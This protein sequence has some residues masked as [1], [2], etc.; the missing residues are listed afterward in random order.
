[1]TG[2]LIVSVS[3][4]RDRSTEDIAEFSSLL[5]KR[6][7]PV[8]YLVAPRLAGGYRLLA[9]TSTV[10]WLRGRRQHGDAIVLHGFD[11]PASKKHRR[12]FADLPAHEASLRLMAADRVLEHVG[13]RTRLFVPPN[14][15]ASTGTVSALP[16]KGFR[17]LSEMGSVTDL[18]RKNTIRARVLGIG[19]GFLTETWWCR[20]LVL[21]AERIARRGGV[22]R[23]SVSARQ[24]GRP[25]PRQAMLDAIDLSLM[26]GA[27]AGVYEW[28]RRPTQAAA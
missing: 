10:D 4:L 22:V 7:V 27:R 19:A 23:L 5:E 3:G 17:L 25:G 15:T 11:V 24:L 28:F 13:L 26:H 8:S 2:T 12:E 1:M 9:D 16:D 20:T 6:N 18:V 21:S 14:W